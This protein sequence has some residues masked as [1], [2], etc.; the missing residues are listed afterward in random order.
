MVLTTDF[1]D[2]TDGLDTKDKRR[3]THAL[4]R[5]SS[6]V[7]SVQS[8]PSVVLSIFQQYGDLFHSF[9]VGVEHSGDDARITFGVRPATILDGLADSGQRLGAVA[10][11]ET[12]GVD[13]VAIP[14]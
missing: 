1:T 11:L 8:V 4:L 12:R 6:S 2:F 3:K 7:S 14:F 9:A 10:G 5:H 13:H